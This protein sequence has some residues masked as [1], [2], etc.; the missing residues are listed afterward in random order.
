MLLIPYIGAEG[1]MGHVQTLRSIRNGMI[2]AVIVLCSVLS[3]QAPTAY[4]NPAPLGLWFEH[5][6]RGAVE[7]E[8]CGKGL[9][10]RLVWLKDTENTK[11]CGLAIIGDVEPVTEGTWDN[12]WIFDPDFGQRFDVE[13]T[14]LEN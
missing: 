8:E 5:T 10:G 7:I 14:P 6:G 1:K 13:L 2:S 4:A 9:C 11:A 12:G 3:V